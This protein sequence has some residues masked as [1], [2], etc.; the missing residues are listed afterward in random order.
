MPD[1]F[2]SPPATTP[3]PGNQPEKPKSVVNLDELD[4]IEKEKENR[5]LAAFITAP[6]NWHFETQE[7]EEKIILILRRHWITNLGWIL[8][9]LILLVLPQILFA[10]F[11]FDFL[12]L[13]FQVVAVMM[14][15]LFL[16]GFIFQRFLDW[17]FNIF[18]ITDERIIDFDFYGLIF[19]EISDADID[20][21]QDITYRV[22]GFLRNMF[23][24]GDV[25]IQTA[26]EI[27]EFEFADVP[28]P[29][30][31]VKILREL[32]SKE[33]MEKLRGIS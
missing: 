10:F 8:T 31:I 25:L 9:S 30:R 27:Q 13:R 18:I 29:E 26:A 24:F 7:D 2:V 20:K 21:I 22:G 32:T 5:P 33:E 1:I 15:Y 4:R 6:K 28:Q 3:K 16:G 23:D 19:K 17:F 12:P 14:W 11:S